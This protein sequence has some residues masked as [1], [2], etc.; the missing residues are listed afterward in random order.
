MLDTDCGGFPALY[1]GTLEITGK[2]C[3]TF[4][5]PEG[6]RHGFIRINGFNIGRYYT[7]RGPQKTL[8]VPAPILKS[9]E[10]VIEV[11]ETDGIGS[12]IITFTDKHDLG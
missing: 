3:D 5:Y 9:G 7:D 11:F 4:I 12:G 2:V 6:F 10:N 8:Y 1:R